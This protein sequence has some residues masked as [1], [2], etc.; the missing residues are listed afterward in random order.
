MSAH[1]ASN[2]AAIKSAKE[3][4]IAQAAL[5]NQIQTSAAS[6]IEAASAASVAINKEKQ[7]CNK[8][9]LESHHKTRTTAGLI[10]RCILA[11]RLLKK[12][13]EQADFNEAQ[14][15]L[16]KSTLREMTAQLEVI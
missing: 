11:K 3:A 7:N 2:A 15:E 14:V 9:M 13:E 10:S 5:D 8:W 4:N 12:T 16:L 1:Y 6:M